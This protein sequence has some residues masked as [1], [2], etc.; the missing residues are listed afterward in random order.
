[1]V[2]S[3][4][5]V[6]LFFFFS[7]SQH[8]FFLTL[9]SLSFTFCCV[10][11]LVQSVGSLRRGLADVQSRSCE[12]ILIDIYIYMYSF[13]FFLRWP[14]LC[15][16]FLL[17]SFPISRICALTPQFHCLLRSVALVPRIQYRLPRA[18]VVRY[19]PWGRRTL[20]APSRAFYCFESLKHPFLAHPSRTLHALGA[21]SIQ[22]GRNG[23]VVWHGKKKTCRGATERGKGWKLH[24]WFNDSEPRRLPRSVLAFSSEQKKTVL[25]LICITT[26][27]SSSLLV[28]FFFSSFLIS[29]ALNLLSLVWFPP[30]CVVAWK[31]LSMAV[32]VSSWGVVICQCGRAVKAIAHIMSRLVPFSTVLCVLSW[33]SMSRCWQAALPLFA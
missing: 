13:F 18:W 21:P 2:L 7:I 6:F 11:V 26:F 9:L 20:N 12:E 14:I 27:N 3:A 22:V 16:F 31:G 15:I 32:S 1:M 24:A 4:K 25:S 19:R 29:F 10:D 8:F 33:S 5:A 30:S 23:R 28:F 17:F